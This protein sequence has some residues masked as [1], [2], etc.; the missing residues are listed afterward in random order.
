MNCNLNFPLMMRLAPILAFLF[1]TN[2]SFFKILFLNNYTL[3]H[4]PH[5]LA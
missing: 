1:I 4:C 5:S 2:C 3:L